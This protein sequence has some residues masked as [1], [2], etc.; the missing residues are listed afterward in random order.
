MNEKVKAFLN[1]KVA[2]ER[3]KYEEEKKKKLLELGLCEKVYSEDDAYSAE[4][5][6]REYDSVT[7]K[8]RWYKRAPI[9]ISDEEYEEIRK[10]SIRT[11]DEDVSDEDNPIAR[12]LKMI[13]WVIFIGGFVAGIFLGNVEVMKGVHYQYTD[14]EFSFAI[15]FSYWCIALISGTMFLG[16]AEIIKLLEDIK[17]K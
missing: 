11:G 13:A 10:Y 4:F 3:K 12:A 15:A 16:F 14:T 1:E 6:C 9:S 2:E 7:S 17:N 8:S 5:P